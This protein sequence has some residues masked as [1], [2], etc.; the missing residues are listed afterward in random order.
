[1]EFYVIWGMRGF[2]MDIGNT[3]YL[4]TITYSSL[5]GTSIGKREV[6]TSP[7][8]RNSFNLDRVIYLSLII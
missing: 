3:H 2:L 1:M 4:G 8:E 7:G 5:V 6:S